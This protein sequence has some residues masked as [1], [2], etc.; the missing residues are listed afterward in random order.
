MTDGRRLIFRDAAIRHYALGRTRSVLPQFASAPVRAL[1]WIVAG[2]LLSFGLL[3]WLIHIP[4]YASGLGVVNESLAPGAAE[5]GE[6]RRMAILLPDEER[7][8]VR[9]GQ[10]VFWSFDNRGG[11]VRLTL[12]AIETEVSSPTAVYERFKLTG[13]A[14]AGITEPVV[15]AFVDLESLPANLPASAFAGNVYRIDVEVGRMRALSMLPFISRF[16]FE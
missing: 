1:L 12:M 8:K 7:S 13:A 16:S 6:V 14:A 3:A 15:V 9:V 11:R 10:K 2:M 5:V 4:V